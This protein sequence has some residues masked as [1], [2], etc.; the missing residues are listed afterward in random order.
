MASVARGGTEAVSTAAYRRGMPLSF[1]VGRYFAYLLALFCLIGALLLAAFGVLL[2]MNVIFPA[3]YAME[4]VDK[5]SQELGTQEHFDARAIPAAFW[6]AHVTAGGALAETDM[7]GAQLERAQELVVQGGESASSLTNPLV[8]G[9]GYAYRAVPLADGSTCVLA[10]DIAPQF[11]DRSLRD[12]LPN[13]QNTLTAAALVA[14]V[15]VLV[16]L[17]LRASHVIRRKME[18]LLDATAHIERQELDFTVDA[19]NVRQVNDVLAAME[20][21]RASLK[22]SLEA[23]W[24]AEAAQR[25]QIAA[26]A[27]D[28]KTPLTVARANAELLVEDAPDDEARACAEAVRDAALRADGYVADIIAASRGET[29]TLQ[30]KPVDLRAFAATLECEARELA[31]AQGVQLEVRNGWSDATECPRWDADALCRAT[32]NLVGNACRYA[33]A[34]SAVRLMLACTGGDTCVIVVEDDGPGF[35]PEA[36]AHGTER[37]FRDDAARSYDREGE[38]VRDVGG[39]VPDRGARTLLEDSAHGHWG[40]GLYTAAQAARA[41]G[42]TLILANRPTGGARATLALPLNE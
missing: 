21:M 10:Y 36:L 29:T 42:G 3:N 4:H 31:S 13:P 2:N 40:L 17:A 5:L 26:L 35:S 27:H 19:S 8:S 11:V 14:A 18:P 1:V 25:E 20:G 41:H 39:R 37:F 33:P 23:Q 30:C 38:G 22:G 6:Y 12:A 32:L 34:G 9:T 16:G 28:L 7:A 24:R 15:A